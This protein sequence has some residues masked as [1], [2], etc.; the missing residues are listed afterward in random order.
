MCQGIE[1]RRHNINV[2]VLTVRGV[3]HARRLRLGC[4]ALFEHDKVPFLIHGGHGDI[5]GLWWFEEDKDVAFR[6][7][8]AGY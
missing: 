6:G 1:R 4:G 3:A 8:P 2:E 5:G 7:Q